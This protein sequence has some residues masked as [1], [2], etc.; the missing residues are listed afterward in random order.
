MVSLGCYGDT[1]ILTL[2]QSR[3]YCIFGFT[4]CFSLVYGY[5][6]YYLENTVYSSLGFDQYW[7][8]YVGM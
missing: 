6:S 4:L 1:F 8:A 7:P 5:M 3:F 2:P